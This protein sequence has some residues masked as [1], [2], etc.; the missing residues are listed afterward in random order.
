MINEQEMETPSAK[1]GF[2]IVEVVI[3]MMIMTVAV[4]AL[5]SSFGL[6]SK[7]MTRGHNAEM[8]SSFSM[9]RMDQLRL[10]GCTARPNGADTLFRGTTNWAAIN[11]WVWTDAGKNNIPG[12]NPDPVTFRV[13]MTTTYRSS[14]GATG[15]NI[16]ETSISCVF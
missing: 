3:A 7:M 14:G 12:A 6:V 16:S 11:N 5:A 1:R 8:A 4:L 2:T 9:G 15:T 10:T 13:K